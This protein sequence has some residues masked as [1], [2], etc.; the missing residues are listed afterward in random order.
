MPG[1]LARILVFARAT[2]CPQILCKEGKCARGF[3]KLVK[4]YRWGL[5]D[6]SGGSKDWRLEFCKR[7]VSGHRQDP[8]KRLDI[9]CRALLRESVESCL[10]EE[11]SML[12]WPLNMFKGLSLLWKVM[13]ESFRIC[14]RT[15]SFRLVMVSIISSDNIE[16]SGNY[17]NASIN[18]ER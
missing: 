15:S 12:K 2:Q 18:I 16:L 8:W 13:R 5:S 9:D 11:R 10:L 17:L 7:N 6:G 4:Q 14:K 1:V 3:I